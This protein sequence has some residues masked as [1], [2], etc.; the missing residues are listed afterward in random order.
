MD[1]NYDY[2]IRPDKYQSIRAHALYCNTVEYM[3]LNNR[4]RQNLDKLED[5]PEKVWW[6]LLAEFI[7]QLLEDEDGSSGAE[8]DE[9]L[10]AKKAKDC[11]GQGCTQET[12]HYS[13]GKRNRDREKAWERFGSRTNQRHCTE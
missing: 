2:S 5:K 13:L 11:A 1:Y 6:L 3:D 12:L 7:E 8:D 4:A 9:R 10:T